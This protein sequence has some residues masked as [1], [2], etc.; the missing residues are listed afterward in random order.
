MIILHSPEKIQLHDF[1]ESMRH[2]EKKGLGIWDGVNR[3]FK[4]LRMVMWRKTRVDALPMHKI[5]LRLLT[6]ERRLR[7]E[8][9]LGMWKKKDTSNGTFKKHLMKDKNSRSK[10]G[11]RKLVVFECTLVHPACLLRVKNMAHSLPSRYHPPHLERRHTRELSFLL[12]QH[13]WSRW[14][15]HVYRYTYVH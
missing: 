2:V 7:S 6:A 5:T 1:W 4:V 3:H 8:G 9:I 13:N 14:F 10:S 12:S 11:V 15:V